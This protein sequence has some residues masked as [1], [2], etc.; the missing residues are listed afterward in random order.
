MEAVIITTKVCSKC[1][2][3]KSLDSFFRCRQRSVNK[4]A[5]CKICS[6]QWAR[7]NKDKINTYARAYRA[8]H[9]Q[10]VRDYVR[11]LEYKNDFGITL[12]DYDRMFEN[13]K[14]FCA[15]CQRHQSC[16]SRRLAVDHD[17]ITGKIRGL[18]CDPCNRGMGMLKEHN[19]QRALDYLGGK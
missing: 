14:G 16:F 2:E 4:A 3:V 12:A 9:P 6:R 17:H 1:K 18:L 7:D 19:L 10:Q 5:Y 8:R 15:I 13:Q 11:K